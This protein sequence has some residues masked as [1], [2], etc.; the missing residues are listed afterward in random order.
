[1]I[2]GNSD[3]EH[4][5]SSTSSDMP[6]CYDIGAS[7]GPPNKKS[8]V[9]PSDAPPSLRCGC[10]PEGLSLESFHAPPE[11]IRGKNTEGQY[12][13]DFAQQVK[14][15]LPSSEDVCDDIAE[16]PFFHIPAQDALDAF[17]HQKSYFKNVDKFSTD[18]KQDNGLQLPGHRPS[19]KS[20][21]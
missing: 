8:K 10:L 14:H 21:R 15:V 6:S 16:V 12:L 4:G 1:M 5:S 3:V 19:K 7:A 11:N 2:S 18:L 13:A 9:L 20:F 17:T